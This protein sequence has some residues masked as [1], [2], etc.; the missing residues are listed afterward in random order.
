[1]LRLLVTC[2]NNF[3]INKT[4]T[5]AKTYRKVRYFRRVLPSGDHYFRVAKTC[6][7]AVQNYGN[8]IAT[9][10]EN[11]HFLLAETIFIL[12]F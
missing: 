10:V 12:L 9:N 7:R 6:T 3:K 11:P 5:T 1:M 8:N 2:G 4:T